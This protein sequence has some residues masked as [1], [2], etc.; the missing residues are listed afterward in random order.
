MKPRLKPRIQTAVL[1]REILPRMLADAGGL[2]AALF[3]AFSVYFIGYAVYWK[4]FPNAWQ[5]EAAFRLLY[6]ENVLLL[7]CLGIGIFW[8]SGFYTHS[9]G[10]QTQYKVLVIVNAVTLT[11]LIE[12]LLYSFVMRIDTVPRG[13]VLLAWMFSLGLIAGSRMLKDRVTNA[14]VITP[15]TFSGRRETKNVLVIGG[16]G[17][18]GS[19]LTWQ[20]VEAGY[21]AR[22]LD[23]LL[24][25]EAPLAGLLNHPNFE[26]Q[27]ADFRHV[28]SLVKAMR[29]V[30]AVIHLAAIVGDPACA[31]NAELTTEINYA[32]TRLLVEVAKGAGV[33]RLIFASTCS[34]YGASDFLMD[35]RSATNPISLYARTKLDSERAILEACSATLDCTCLRMATVFGLSPRPR[36]DLVVNLLTARA[37]QERKIVISNREQ[38]RPFIHVN[39]AARAFLRVLEA[40]AHAVSGEIFNVGSYHLNYTL[41]EVAEMIRARVPGVEVEYRES[42]DKRN[43]RVSFDKIHSRLG[44]VGTTS[45]EEGIEEIRQAVVSGLVKD[46]RDRL[47]SNH[48][49]LLGAPED[50]LRREPAVQMFTLLE[51]AD[52]AGAPAGVKSLAAGA[53]G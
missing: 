53:T 14:F 8:L 34:I 29:N 31:L 15:K 28:E 30:D 45:L 40:P 2:C 35:E 23:S 24:F 10:Y 43:Y 17:Y 50:L 19:S 47:F 26:L 38:W 39:D 21:R 36:F 52:A 6:L 46:Y 37:I 11:Y 48:D 5:L 27:R 12:V 18:I 42:P 33:G 16:A 32:A 13:V 41:G 20:L 3:F 44:F 49:Y 22:V 4:H 7:L 1:L 9:R 25:S 51:P